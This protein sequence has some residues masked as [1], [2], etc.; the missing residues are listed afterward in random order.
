M[1]LALFTTTAFERDLKRVRKQG[2]DPDKLEAVV[3]LIQEQR[4]LPTRCR[5]HPLRGN[6][7]GHWDCHIQPDWLPLYKPTDTE[8]TLIRTGSARG[9]V[10]V[11]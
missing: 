10:R 4:P 9:A 1:P 5:P 7:I 6:W 3:D 11:D 8:L 2:G